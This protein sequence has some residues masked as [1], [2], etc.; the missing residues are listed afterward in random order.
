VQDAD[1]DRIRAHSRRAYE[2]AVLAF[3][4]AST[5]ADLARSRIE[6]S[7]QTADKCQALITRWSQTSDSAGLF[8]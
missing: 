6:N 5:Y 2:S 7:V 3:E 1:V 8:R 4:R